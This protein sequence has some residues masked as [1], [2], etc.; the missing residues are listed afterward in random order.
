METKLTPEQLQELDT[1]IDNVRNIE[2]EKETRDI[3]K[4]LE[5]LLK[6]RQEIDNQILKYQ[7]IHKISWPF[8]LQE[9][10]KIFNYWYDEWC[11]YMHSW[12]QDEMNYR[13]SRI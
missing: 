2:K 8:D 3:E 10:Q 9:L 7:F 13:M 12:M 5:D 6:K 4:W 11:R 1:A